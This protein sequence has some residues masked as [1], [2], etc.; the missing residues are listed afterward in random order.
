MQ[1]LLVEIHS[2]LRWVLLFFLLVTIFKSLMGW[3]GNQSW[4]PVDNQLSLLTLIFTHTQLIVGLILYFTS[5]QVNFSD[6]VSDAYRFYT[7]EHITG[8]LIAI[9]LITVGRVLAKKRTVPKAKFK[10]TTIFFALGLIIMISM[11]RVW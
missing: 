7:M 11:I 9:I 5:P 4:K 8:M 10:V 6:P 1:T 2:V 3:V